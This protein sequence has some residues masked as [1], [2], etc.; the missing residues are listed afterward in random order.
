MSLLYSEYKLN[1]TGNINILKD[2]YTFNYNNYEK[3]RSA[4]E[5]NKVYTNSMIINQENKQLKEDKRI[6]NLSI[7]QI[8]N[9]A[10]QSYINLINDLSVFFN[11][12]KQ[13]RTLNQFGYII[14]KDDN[15][16]YIGLLIIILSLILYLLNISK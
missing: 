4:Q 2:D 11:K 1:N 5:Y 3:M 10:S 13:D 8:L 16:I 6:Y 14:T 9:N 7:K 12:D 15:L